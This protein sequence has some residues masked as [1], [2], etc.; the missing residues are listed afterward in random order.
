M[1]KLKGKVALVTGSARGIGA[2]IAER[3]AADG[4][5]VAINYSKSAQPAEDVAERVRRAGARAV[6]IQADLG[7]SAQVEALVEHTV[8]EL[9][10]LDILVNNAAAFSFGPVESIE[11]TELRRNLATN[12]E[13]PIAMLKAAIRHLPSEGG[14]IINITSLLQL[15]PLPGST[16]YAACKGALDAMTRTWAAE[17][18]ARG[19]TVNAVGPG[20]VDT[21]A[22][23]DNVNEETKRV[24]VSRTPLGR[25]GTPSDV[26][27]VVA[28]LASPDARWVTG[29]VLMA[30]GG[31][32]P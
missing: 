30:S 26:A 18:G 9:G 7:E 3:L 12:I 6:V 19:I 27:D 13:G 17:L 32:T 21:D 20:A 14:R 15:Y 28:F 11:H 5:D 29:H 16:V 31:F 22:F 23:R 25:I 1:N 8:R 2:A 10:R 4:A 24:F